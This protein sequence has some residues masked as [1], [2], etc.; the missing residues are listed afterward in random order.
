MCLRFP[1]RLMMSEIGF[2]VRHHLY[3]NSYMLSSRDYGDDLL[4]WGRA[5]MASNCGHHNHTGRCSCASRP[6]RDTRHPTNWQCTACR[7]GISTHWDAMNGSFHFPQIYSIQPTMLQQT[8]R[9]ETGRW[10][11]STL[12]AWRDKKLSS[13]GR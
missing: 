9:G 4:H 10:L 5:Q 1:P 2:I 8:I 6:H 3:C 13:I 7:S 12:A 11:Y